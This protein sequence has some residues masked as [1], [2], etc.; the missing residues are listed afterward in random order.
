V[1]VLWQALSMDYINGIVIKKLLILH[2]K[3]MWAHWRKKGML[4]GKLLKK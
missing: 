1:I 2:K 3:R 4:P